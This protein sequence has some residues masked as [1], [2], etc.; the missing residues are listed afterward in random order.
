MKAIITILIF[1][2]LLTFLIFSWKYWRCCYKYLFWG[3]FYILKTINLSKMCKK[4]VKK[5]KERKDNYR[6]DTFEE[7]KDVSVMKW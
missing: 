6:A 4:K 2:L 5:A 1:V 3:W 7:S